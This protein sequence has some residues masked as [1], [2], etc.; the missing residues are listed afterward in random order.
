MFEQ[1]EFPPARLSL[2]Q[3]THILYLM[4]GERGFSVEAAIKGDK[5]KVNYT[6]RSQDG[7]VFESSIGL[8]PL[9]FTIGSGEVVKGFEDAVIG[10]YPGQHKI[11][12]VDPEEG[13]GMY[14]ESL[15]IE[16]SLEDIPEDLDI[17][18]GM[19]FEVEDD[20]G[21]ILPATVIEIMDDSILVDANAPLAGKKVIYDIELLEIVT[22]GNA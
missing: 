3:P 13:F 8:R 18:V 7:Q 17:Q 22:G 14:D 12:T 19:D 1:R 6:G 5:V 10:M 16:I 2:T 20:E 11:V 4:E 21:N 15:V 9:T